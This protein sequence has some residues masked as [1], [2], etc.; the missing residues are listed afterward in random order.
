MQ[1]SVSRYIFTSVLLVLVAGVVSWLLE[2]VVGA[3]PIE[4]F[5]FPMN[6]ILIALWGIAVVELYRARERSVVARYLLSASA[7]V[8]AIVLSAVGCIVVGLQAE[9]ATQ[10]YGFV[11]LVVYVMTVL[12][13][14]T[15][16]GWYVGGVRWRFLFSHL[17]LLLALI[18]GF[19]GAADYEELRMIVDDKPRREA[20]YIDGTATNLDYTLRLADFD[21]EYGA[22]GVPEQYRADIEV[23]NKIVTLEVN[24]PYKVRFGERVYLMNFDST[25]QG[26]RLVVQIVRQPWQGLMVVGIVMMIFGALLMFLGGAKR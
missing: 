25:E 6:V 17:G 13:M 10:S 18:A 3:F 22:S 19:W 23:D 4:F 9:P 12:A 2:T 24:D 1:F 16:R 5:A 11:L 21:V 7:T 15:L 14:V 8:T 26:V 20:I